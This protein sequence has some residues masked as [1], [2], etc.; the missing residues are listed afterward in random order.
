MVEKE[1]LPRNLTDRILDWIKRPEVIAIKGPR[2]AGKTTL[3]SIIGQKLIQ[4]GT[5]PGAITTISF[6]N[7]RQLEQ[8]E[9]RPLE[10]V[11]SFIF[12]E[13]ESKQYLFFD[14]YQY[15]K[16]G[17]QKLKLVYDTYAPRLK[18]I[19]TG[20]SSLELTSEMARFMVGRMLSAYL[21]PFAF[22]EFLRAKDE[23]LHRLWKERNQLLC[24]FLFE[25]RLVPEEKKEDIFLEEFVPH[26]K[27]YLTFG[28]YPA[29]VCEPDEELKRTL[30][31]NLIDTYVERDIVRL[32]GEES[33]TEFRNLTRILASQTGQ[34]LNYQQLASDTTLYFRKVKHFLSVLEETF[35]IEELRPFHGN[36]A[37]ELR[38]NPKVYFLDSGLRNSLVDNFAG[39]DFRADRGELVESAVLANI[40]YRMKSKAEVLFW[41]TTGG[42]EVDFIIRKG[43]NLAPVEVKYQSMNSSK[44]SRSLHS[45]IENYKPQ[46]VLVLTKDFWGTKSVG[47]TQILF[48]PVW[49]FAPPT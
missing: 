31:E 42:A 43:T 12:P 45:Y 33:I 6:E 11:E 23:R 8:F 20:S 39:L 40:I 13:T 24:N 38:K 44:V 5:S 19:I 17:G 35:L 2:Q 18:I 27:K 21:F 16:E 32:L 26:W 30:L 22:D 48:A 15:V 14:E 25:N 7:R 29:I 49:Y 36:L 34:L 46:S 28:G 47:K 3:L 10:F 4:Q 41:R 1:F 9:S 37:T